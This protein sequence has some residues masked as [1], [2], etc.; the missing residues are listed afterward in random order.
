M[1]PRPGRSTKR[2]TGVAPGFGRGNT[3]LAPA[4]AVHLVSDY[5]SRPARLDT[6]PE[7]LEELV[8]PAGG[9]QVGEQRSAGG[10]GV[11]DELVGQLVDQPAVGGGDHAVAGDVAAQPRHLRSGEVGVEDQPGPLGEDVLVLSQLGAEAPFRAIAAS[12]SVQ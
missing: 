3:R 9:V 4:L 6:T 11:G 10:G 2:P 1:R 8:V 7:Q 5:L 12:P